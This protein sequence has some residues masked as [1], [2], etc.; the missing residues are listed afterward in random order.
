MD[1]RR[2][3]STDQC[4]LEL[5]ERAL[6]LTLV[7]NAVETF[8]RTGDSPEI[9]SGNSLTLRQAAA[10]VTITIK[11][12]LRGCIGLLKPGPLDRILVH[13]A[14]AA[15]S[16]DGRFQ[17]VTSTELPDIRYEIS[18]LSPL[19]RAESPEEVEVGRHGILLRA[20]GAQGLLLPRL[21]WSMAGT[22][23]RF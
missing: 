3:G 12:T 10:F 11:N 23:R 18:V 16:E 1:Q 19:R 8:V 22:T 15:A 21:P 6:A 4:L 5:W 2:P 20:R 7:R 17:P 14:I 9:P 13:C